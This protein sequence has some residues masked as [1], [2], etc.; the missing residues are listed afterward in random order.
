MGS[1]ISSLPAYIDKNEFLKIVN[2][3]RYEALFNLYAVDGVISRED[4]IQLSQI[5]DCYISFD[6]DDF[7]SASNI[8]KSFESNGLRVGL[9]NP[10]NYNTNR[11]PQLC[12]LID[13]S[14]T[15]I[16]L[17][18][19]SYKSKLN[20]VAIEN[21]ESVEYLYC[22]KT[23]P[24]SHTI[25]FTPDSNIINSFV[26]QQTSFFI[27]STENRFL[28]N[29]LGTKNAYD[30]ISSLCRMKA[31]KPIKLNVISDTTILTKDESQLYMWMSRC[32]KINEYCRLVY[33]IS[34]IQKNIVNIQ[35]LA[36]RLMEDPLFLLSMGFLAKDADELGI[37]I[38]D[39]CVGYIHTRDFSSFDTLE[40]VTFA[41]KKSLEGQKNH[42]L[43]CS[44]LKCV[45]QYISC[46]TL[47][48][49]GIDLKQQQRCRAKQIYDIGFVT[50]LVKIYEEHFENSLVLLHACRVITLLIMNCDESLVNFGD[51][52]MCFVIVRSMRIYLTDA[53]FI[54]ESCLAVA[55]LSGNN[56]N[57]NKLGVASVCDV[58]CKIMQLNMNDKCVIEGVCLAIENLQIGV[59]ENTTKLGLAGVNLLICDALKNHI[60]SGNVVE[61]IFKAMIRLNVDVENRNILGRNVCKVFV[62]ALNIHVL[63]SN[64]VIAG[65][66]V[67][68]SMIIS[69]S[70]NREQLAINNIGNCLNVIINDYYTN[71]RNQDILLFSSMAIYSLLNGSPNN[72][73][74]F[75]GIK[76]VLSKV[77]NEVK[78]ISPDTI[79]KVKEAI[80]ILS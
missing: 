57:R 55:A 28:L 22:S 39:L 23:K 46:K 53:N 70:A 33:S 63:N 38:Q 78:D 27:K 14:I 26:Q 12:S 25:V 19:E 76:E 24:K 44:S 50:V 15:V 9:I 32:S 18:T 16:I 13:N 77:L 64:I 48:I 51:S 59:Y 29:D 17:F 34:I 60:S 6:S 41:I 75:S 20:A 1:G 69:C 68:I 45:E 79:G 49:D 40:E 21:Q 37:A 56:N 2:N 54:S 31:S 36:F 8:A 52:T 58:L 3:H 43:C 80:K 42:K 10:N 4:F 65:C 47:E 35:Q 11:I 73:Q 72:R 5:K 71:N 7:V 61:K 62:E 67:V 30:Y 74:K 66:Q